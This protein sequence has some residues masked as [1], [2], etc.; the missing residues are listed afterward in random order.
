MTNTS[1]NTEAPCRIALSLSL[2]AQTWSNLLPHNRLRLR[3]SPSVPRQTGKDIWY[4]I[5]LACVPLHR[6][7]IYTTQSPYNPRNPYYGYEYGHGHPGRRRK[8]DLLRTLMYLF[9]LRLLAVRR[10]MQRWGW[11]WMLV[12]AAAMVGARRIKKPVA[13]T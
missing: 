3:W 9:S 4:V 7:H 13:K 11:I 12:G 2:C 10:H 1:Q 8:R 6:A 5:C